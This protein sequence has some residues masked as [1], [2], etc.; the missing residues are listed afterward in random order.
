MLMIVNLPFSS[1]AMVKVQLVH[2]TSFNMQVQ[3]SKSWVICN[4]SLT[5]SKVQCS[6]G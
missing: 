4:A 5:S 3:F 1:S 2:M 6:Y